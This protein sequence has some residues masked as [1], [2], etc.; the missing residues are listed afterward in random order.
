MNPDMT[1]ADNDLRV[2]ITWQEGYV[3]VAVS[4]DV[5]LPTAAAR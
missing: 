1:V 5:D 3:T 2:G 4:G